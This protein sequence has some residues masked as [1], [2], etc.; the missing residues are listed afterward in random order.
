LDYSQREDGTHA[1]SAAA[2]RWHWF[3]FG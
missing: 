1:I 3:C 2:A